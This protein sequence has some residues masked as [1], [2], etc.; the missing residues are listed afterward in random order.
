MKSYVTLTVNEQ[1]KT[2]EIENSSN[3]T[4]NSTRR[5]LQRKRILFFKKFFRKVVNVVKA[6][7]KPVVEL[8]RSA[9]P[10][11]GAAVGAVTG[12]VVGGPLMAFEMGKQGYQIGS[13]A[14]TFVKSCIPQNTLRLKCDS[15]YLADRAKAVALNYL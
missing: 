14:Q 4:N 3:N 6:V 2:M 9:G 15:Q 8:V 7:V 13:T 12:F 5:M 1:D 11:I 10:I